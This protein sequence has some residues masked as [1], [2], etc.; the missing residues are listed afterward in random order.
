VFSKTWTES[1]KSNSKIGWEFEGFLRCTT[2]E[3]STGGSD[4]ADW[5]LPLLHTDLGSESF[6]MTEKIDL[7][8]EFTWLRWSPLRWSPQLPSAIRAP[9]PKIKK[10]IASTQGAVF[11]VRFSRFVDGIVK[12]P[13][14]DR[15][16]ISS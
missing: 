1:V 13:L 2:S 8:F 11:P 5:Q 4:G 16:Q 10:T 7:S 9:F 6:P 12:N 14:S 3:D 15:T